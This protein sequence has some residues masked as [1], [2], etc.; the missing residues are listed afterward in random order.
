MTSLPADLESPRA[1]L[2][3]LYLQSAEGATIEEL[4]DALDIPLIT[5]LPTVDVLHERSLVEVHDEWYVST[6]TASRS[7]SA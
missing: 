5:L 2:I 4:R 6:P 1:K 7:E 3:Y